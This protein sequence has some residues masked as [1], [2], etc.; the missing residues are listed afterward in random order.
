[1]GCTRFLWGYNSQYLIAKIDNASYAE[2][3]G[4]LGLSDQEVDESQLTLMRCAIA[5]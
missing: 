3:Q 5:K 1:M 4:A 2:V